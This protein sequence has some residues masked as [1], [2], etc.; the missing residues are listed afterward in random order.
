VKG[1]ENV[2]M[3]VFL[4]GEKRKLDEENKKK[5]KIKNKEDIAI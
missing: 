5:D 4:P 3:S 2:E 1:L